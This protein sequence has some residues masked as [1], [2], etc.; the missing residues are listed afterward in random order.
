MSAHEKVKWINAPWFT[1]LLIALLTGGA[2]CIYKVGSFV[3]HLDDLPERVAHV[4]Q[5]LEA[6]QTTVEDM[7]AQNNAILR[8][9]GIAWSDGHPVVITN[10]A[11]SVNCR[12]N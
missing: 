1:T 11:A 2:G 7:R 10:I 4:E 5:K 12:H 8:L 3:V 9:Y 6:V